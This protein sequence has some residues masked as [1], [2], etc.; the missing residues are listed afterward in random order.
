M[1]LFSDPA[2]PPS[3]RR[4]GRQLL[5]HGAS[6]LALMGW[7]TLAL[8]LADSGSELWWLALP[9]FLAALVGPRAPLATGVVEVVLLAAGI[10]LLPATHLEWSVVAAALVL[11]GRAL[12]SVL[13][14]RARAL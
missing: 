9:G 4:A 13:V 1:P 5:R 8:G 3:L 7:S 11:F 12:Q 10:A 14:L 2:E 6:L